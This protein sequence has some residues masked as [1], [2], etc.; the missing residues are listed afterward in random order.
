MRGKLD[1]SDGY[2]PQLLWGI[3]LSSPNYLL[4]QKPE[5]ADTVIVFTEAIDFFLFK[6]EH[7]SNPS[8]IEYCSSLLVK[9]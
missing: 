2:L 6:L 3:A 5:T 1:V 4:Q 8:K 7:L 9:I